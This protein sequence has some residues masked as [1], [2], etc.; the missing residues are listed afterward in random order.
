[1][2]SVCAR[3][4]DCTNVTVA[5]NDT[6]PSCCFTT[7]VCLNKLKYAIRNTELMDADFIDRRATSGWENVR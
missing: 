1:M 7:Q 3:R 5:C 6:F 2:R 4:E